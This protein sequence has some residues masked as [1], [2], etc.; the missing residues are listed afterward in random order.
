M[1]LK[2]NDTLIKGNLRLEG[3][4]ITTADFSFQSQKWN[5]NQPFRT[6]I[7]VG[8]PLR[9]SQIHNAFNHLKVCLNYL[10]EIE[11]Q[12][13][14]LDTTLNAVMQNLNKLVEQAAYSIKLARD[15]ILLPNRNLFPQ[16]TFASIHSTQPTVFQPSLPQD[17]VVELSVN[18]RQL[19][20]SVFFLHAMTNPPPNQ[21]QSSNKANGTSVGKTYKCVSQG[22]KYWA[23]VVDQ[24]QISC[25]ADILDLMFSQ[26]NSAYELCIDLRD[27]I[28]LFL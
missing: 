19:V 5:K 3:W 13:G 26:I 7:T 6:Q 15:E 2:L 20:I 16:T 21:L 23:E 17:L 28:T 10:Q 24:I 4:S 18:N 25:Q 1:S 12:S 22:S 14:A 9:L 11:A 27:K 8:S